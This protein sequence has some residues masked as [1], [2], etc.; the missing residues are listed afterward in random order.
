MP[1]VTPT[2]PNQQFL[3]RNQTY[4]FK[5]KQMQA[6]DLIQKSKTLP[7]AQRLKMQ[8]QARDI[9][10][11]S[12]NKMQQNQQQRKGVTYQNQNFDNATWAG[13]KHL[14][15]Q[16]AR[17]ATLGAFDGFFPQDQSD[18]QLHQTTKRQR[19]ASYD[20][21]LKKG[22]DGLMQPINWLHG[23]QYDWQKNWQNSLDNRWKDQLSQKDKSVVNFT[24]GVVGT[25][26]NLLGDTLMGAGAAK[27]GGTALNLASKVKGLRPITTGIKSLYNGS[28]LQ[29]AIQH[30][31][32][33]A[34]KAGTTGIKNAYNGVKNSY[35]YI[36]AGNGAWDTTKRIGQ[37]VSKPLAQYMGYSAGESAT[38]YGIN[39]LQ[40]NIANSNMNQSQ[41]AAYLNMLEKGRGLASVGAAFLNP[42]GRIGGAGGLVR[43]LFT[44]GGL[45]QAANAAVTPNMYSAQGDY[46]TALAR[47]QQTGS[48][49]P[50]GVNT[51]EQQQK[52]LRRVAAN[53]A[54]KYKPTFNPIQ[55]AVTGATSRLGFAGGLLP[56][57]AI[58]AGLQAVGMA[59]GDQ[60]SN[61]I[62]VAAN[63]LQGLQ[64]AGIPEGFSPEAIKQLAHDSIQNT[65]NSSFWTRGKIG[66]K[67]L[68]GMDL[69][70]EEKSAAVTQALNG[71]QS[72]KKPVMD[73]FRNQYTATTNLMRQ[74]INQADPAKKQALADQLRANN[75]NQVTATRAMSLF[76]AD[77]MQQMT[78][79]NLQGWSTKQLAGLPAAMQAIG[80]PKTQAGRMMS[81]SLKYYGA[82][83]VVNNL[84]QQVAKSDNIM[85]MV[86]DLLALKK[87]QGDNQQGVDTSRLQNLVAGK[88]WTGVMQDPIKNMPKAISLFLGKSGMPGL[89]Q[90]VS[91][92]LVFF[93]G[94]ALLVGAPLLFGG[95]GGGNSPQP[96]QAPADPQTSNV[97]VNGPHVASINYS[98]APYD[99][100]TSNYLRQ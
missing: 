36:K 31:V 5:L 66:L 93:G 38:N 3:D 11:G 42:A 21:G 73:A 28:K 95:M 63:N 27:L 19:V 35:N 12:V 92:P 16:Y 87:A 85:D 91:D 2:I 48:I 59:P 69:N 89:G 70:N 40:Y 86:P 52:Y 7:E 15:N 100:Y 29:N 62:G 54:V 49:F 6:K 90:A 55:D 64:Q 45:M 33:T 75:K 72:F 58:N 10:A 79:N 71:N 41:K 61:R 39:Q 56:G 1:L 82:Q 30:P 22:V 78:N 53:T 80:G 83:A 14:A 81:Q 9:M 51:P 68:V 4:D 47:Q 65:P 17:D 8:Q 18:K 32:S 74:Y 46:N 24:S 84:Q 57:M 76:N 96:Q 26:V 25:G 23:G 13:F 43:S 97:A 37:V 88:M 67:N 98:K 34:W 77:Q 20:Y 99:L 44:G 60:Q 50:A 94:L